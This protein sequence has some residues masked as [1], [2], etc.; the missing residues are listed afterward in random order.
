MSNIIPFRKFTT[1]EQ[2]SVAPLFHASSLNGVGRRST[3]WQI[4]AAFIHQTEGQVT[5]LI[6]GNEGAIM[7]ISVPGQPH[8]GAMYVYMAANKSFGMLRAGEREDNLN[9]EDFDR[10]NRGQQLTRLVSG[11]KN[12]RRTRRSVVRRVAVA[13]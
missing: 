4:L 13:I 1:T 10:L 3:R 11:H 5:R 8:S 2:I 7:L 6:E 12:H 9:G